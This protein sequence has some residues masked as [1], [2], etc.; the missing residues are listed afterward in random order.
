MQQPDY[1]PRSERLTR[2]LE[3]KILGGVC[4]GIARHYGYDTTVV[5][6]VAVLLTLVWGAGVLVYAV[7]WMV[8]PADEQGHSIPIAGSL[9]EGSS[10]PSSTSSTPRPPFVDEDLADRAKRAAEEFAVAAR[11][12][13]ETARVAAEQFA[14]VAKAA[15]AAGRVAW[16]QQQQQRAAAA[17]T[18]SAEG[19]PPTANTASSSDAPTTPATPPPPPMTPPPPE[20]QQP[21]PHEDVKPE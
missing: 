1:Q 16:D 4:A 11:S 20:Q 17:R 15:A 3:H 10:D 7:L 12:A 8:M 13:A 2:D 18:E 14:E 6:V 21:L 9:G 19:T 5:R